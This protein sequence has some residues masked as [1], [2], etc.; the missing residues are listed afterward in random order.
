MPFAFSKSC[1]TFGSVAPNATGDRRQSQFNC[2]VVQ[3]GAT[4]KLRAQHRHPR[5]QQEENAK[6]MCGYKAIESNAKIN[7]S[8]PHKA[9]LLPPVISKRMSVISEYFLE[10]FHFFFSFWPETMSSGNS[11]SLCF[12][13]K[14]R[15]LSHS[16]THC[17]ELFSNLN[18]SM[19]L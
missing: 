6:E 5:T 4:Q 8:C 12:E 1:S 2:P 14:A 9:P 3:A 7:I 15:Q 18:D 10:C 13:T 11:L 17:V 16:L 19:V